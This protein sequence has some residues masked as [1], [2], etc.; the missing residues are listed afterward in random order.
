M[1]VCSTFACPASTASQQRDDYR[2]LM[3]RAEVSQAELVADQ[4]KRVASA[5]RILRIALGI[6][7]LH[8]LWAVAGV[9]LP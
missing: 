6:L 3:E 5:M 7:L 1:S 2:G 9:F 8:V 4:A